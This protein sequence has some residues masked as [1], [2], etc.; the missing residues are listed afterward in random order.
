LIVD[1]GKRHV[2]FLIYGNFPFLLLGACSRP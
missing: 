2:L 1:H